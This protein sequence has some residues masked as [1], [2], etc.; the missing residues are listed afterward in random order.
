MAAE[1]VRRTEAGLCLGN[2]R[3]NALAVT[4]AL[5]RRTGVGGKD[6]LPLDVQAGE[7]VHRVGGALASDPPGESRSGGG[8]GGGAEPQN[9]LAADGSIRFSSEPV[10]VIGLIWI[11]FANP[12]PSVIRWSYD[13][14]VDPRGTRSP[15][16]RV[17]AAAFPVQV[18]GSS[19]GRR[20]WCRSG[21]D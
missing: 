6:V 8:E 20:R 19:R 10:G 9:S 2:W 1:P 12:G 18:T 16:P 17:R 7:H 13:P 14:G 21:S 15:P 5:A 11:I 3:A 4:A